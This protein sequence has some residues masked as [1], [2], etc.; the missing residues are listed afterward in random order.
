MFLLAY[1]PGMKQK[2]RVETKD[3]FQTKPC[4]I[5]CKPI[6]REKFYTGKR[7]F[8]FIMHNCMQI[9]STHVIFFTLGIFTLSKVIHNRNLH[10]YISPKILFKCDVISILQ[11]IYLF[12]NVTKAFFFRKCKITHKISK[13]KKKNHSK[14]IQCWKLTI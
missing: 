4:L 2:Y 5:M 12:V 14:I 3:G 10:F 7:C 1:M 13:K 9:I 8:C 6:L 11:Y